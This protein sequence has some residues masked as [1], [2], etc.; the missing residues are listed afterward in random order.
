MESVLSDLFCSL[1][2]LFFRFR[3]ELQELL[4]NY[5][6]KCVNIMKTYKIYPLGY[7]HIICMR[8]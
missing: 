3:L 6:L 8:H 5:T 4:L 2:D 1:Q 7:K